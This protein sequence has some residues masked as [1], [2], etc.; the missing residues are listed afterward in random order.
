MFEGNFI[1]PCP[2]RVV[3]QSHRGLIPADGAVDKGV[4]FSFLLLE[5]PL[6]LDKSLIQFGGCDFRRRRPVDIEHAADC[7]AEEGHIAEGRLV[8]LLEG[9][10]LGIG[11]TV[12]P[13][14]FVFLRRQ[15]KQSMGHGQNRLTIKD[16]GHLKMWAVLVLLHPLLLFPEVLLL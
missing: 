5:E 14:T 13:P 2:G 9:G 12:L 4:G 6:L 1:A 11:V 15:L 8:L 16:I 10:Q 3:A 7:I